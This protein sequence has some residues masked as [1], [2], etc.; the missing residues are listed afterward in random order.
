MLV[1]A[2]RQQFPRLDDIYGSGAEALVGRG[3]KNVG[4]YDM[5]FTDMF[6]IFWD[7]IYKK[8]GF[9]L[10]NDNDSNHPPNIY[11]YMYIYV[12]IYLYIYIS[13]YIY[14]CIYMYIYI[15]IYICIYLSRTTTSHQQPTTGAQSWTQ[16]SNTDPTWLGGRDGAKKF[17]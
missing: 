1:W 13:V 10:V 15:C 14:I 6:D 9:M 2:S 16:F 11:I 5:L 3:E 17:T 8:F 7:I 12:Y 4:V